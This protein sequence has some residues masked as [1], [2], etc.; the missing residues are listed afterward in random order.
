MTPW[1]II[2]LYLAVVCSAFA[3]GTGGGPAEAT[4]RIKAR[5]E[6]A[7]AELKAREEEVYVKHIFQMHSNAA[8]GSNLLAITVIGDHAR[9]FWPY[10]VMK[11]GSKVD[12][13]IPRY[14]APSSRWGSL[15][16]KELGNLRAALAALPE[17]SAS[18]PLG[19]TVLVSYRSGTNWVTRTYDFKQQ[20]AALREVFQIIGE[21]EEL[22]TTP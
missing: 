4:A 15:S 11:D 5:I 16:E 20:S 18:P 12:Y 19:R 22:K 3:D 13:R 10:I 9:I 6:Q 21:R 2:L 8:S 1:Q 7:R 14:D 17:Q